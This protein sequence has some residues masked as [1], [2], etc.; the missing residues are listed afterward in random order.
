MTAQMEPPTVVDLLYAIDGT[1]LPKDHRFELMS[2]ITR[3]LPWMEAE[4]DVGIHHI[5]AA[6]ADDGGFLL[7]KRTKLVIRLPD[8]RLAGAAELIGQELN[9]CGSILR[10]RAS[11]V[12]SL[13]PHGTLYAHFVTAD[14]DDEQAFL[15]EIGA[16]LGELKIPCKLVCGKRHAFPADQRQI[17]GYSLMLHDLALEHSILV[18]QIGLG[19]DRMLGCGI[20]VPHRSAAAVGTS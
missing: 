19:G 6:R 5:R 16:R 20:F 11:V 18:Q 8:R 14:T 12:R 17:V 1:A 9:V 2:E 3:C 10:V 13:V 7:P 15:A 4:T